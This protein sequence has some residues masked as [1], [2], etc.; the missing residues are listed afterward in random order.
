LFAVA[1]EVG[2]ARRAGDLAALRHVWARAGEEVLRNPMDLY[3]LLPLGEFAVAAARL[4]DTQRLAAHLATASAQLDRCGDP[5]LYRAWLAFTLTNAAVVAERPQQVAAQV[6]VLHR[7]AGHGPFQALLADAARCLLDVLAGRP[8]AESVQ[9]VAQRLHDAGLRFDAARLAG[10]AAIRTT[11]RA[12]M[13]ELLDCARTLAGGQPESAGQAVAPQRLSRREQEVARLV[14]GG[15]TYREIG[16]R[17]FISAKT[18]EHHV[19]RMRQRLG[20]ANRRELLAR[21]RELVHD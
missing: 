14:V 11:D 16:D 5:P 4:G 10:Q 20:C 12:A 8:D 21:L 19:A 17:L 9:A 6:E 13:V 1:V 7:C 15:M 18:V 2:L 3:S